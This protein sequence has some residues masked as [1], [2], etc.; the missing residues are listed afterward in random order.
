M[1][2]HGMATRECESVSGCGLQSEDDE[3]LVEVAHYAAAAQRS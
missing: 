3:T 1:C 2:L